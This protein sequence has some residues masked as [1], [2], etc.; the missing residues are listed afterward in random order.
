MTAPIQEN[1]RLCKYV[2]DV[3]NLPAFY[4]SLTPGSDHVVIYYSTF[5]SLKKKKKITM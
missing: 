5:Y 2:L 4:D 1:E 3:S